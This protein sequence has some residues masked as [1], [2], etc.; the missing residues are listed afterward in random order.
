[1][2]TSA[3]ITHFMTC[4]SRTERCSAD[5]VLAPGVVLVRVWDG[6][7][8]LLDLGGKFYG[9]TPGSADMLMRAL[10]RGRDQAATEIAIE[11][12]V[13]TATV[14]ADLTS[15]LDEL[16]NDGLLRPK[17]AAA[18]RAH[19]L[20]TPFEY[21]IAGTISL[22]ARPGRW[23]STRR[24]LLFAVVH[25]LIRTLGWPQTVHICR[26][27]ARSSRTSANASTQPPVDTDMGT[28]DRLIRGTASRHLLFVE[29]KERA[30]C[31][32]LVMRA[33][34]FTAR[35]IVGIDLFP[36]LGHCWCASGQRVIADN[37][38]RCVRFTPVVEYA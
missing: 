9:L 35:V 8:R 27:A 23:G 31:S 29:C 24:W 10:A 36:F 11:T 12:G 18:P 3:A 38:D 28:I 32:Y 30:L 34:G 4:D 14:R 6:S 25:F 17:S 21:C 26:L 33:A 20:L 15:F 19:G 5:H 16:T 2:N 7:A 22:L 1:M 13:E 37:E